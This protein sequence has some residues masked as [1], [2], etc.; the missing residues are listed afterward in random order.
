LFFGRKTKLAEPDQ[1]LVNEKILLQERKLKK[2]WCVMI[3]N[4]KQTK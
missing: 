4:S 2:H 3:A 1:V